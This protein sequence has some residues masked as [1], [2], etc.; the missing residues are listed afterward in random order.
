MAAAKRNRNM[1][2]TAMYLR[3]AAMLQYAYTI[4]DPSF[5]AVSLWRVPADARASDW[6][7]L[8]YG[9]IELSSALDM[10]TD[11][12][13][14][15]DDVALDLGSGTGKVPLTMAI[16][17]KVGKVIGVEIVKERFDAA[18]QA[19]ARL[20]AIGVPDLL[21]RVVLIN[22]DIRNVD[23]RD[24]TVVYMANT[25]FDPD[26]MLAIVGILVALPKL[27]RVIVTERLCSRHTGR[28]AKLGHACQV[29]KELYSRSIKVTW[30]TGKTPSYTVYDVVRDGPASPTTTCVPVQ[31][32][33]PTAASRSDD[34][35]QIFFGMGGRRWNFKLNA[36]FTA[37]EVARAQQRLFWIEAGK[38]DHPTK[39]THRL[40][41]D[42]IASLRAQVDQVQSRLRSPLALTAKNLVKSPLCGSDNE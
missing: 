39:G 6:K 11:L 21:E 41:V 5:N 16:A 13:L 25:V 30:Q 33:K 24:V 29:F 12:Q 7:S 17:T 19:L 4:E 8:A 23:L 22:D 40:S 10:V 15:P 28:C 37:T 26:L 1:G 9:E 38:V 35:K 14:T 34:D 36:P 3:V 27:R 31:L 2:I 42:E 18:L 32:F 20:I